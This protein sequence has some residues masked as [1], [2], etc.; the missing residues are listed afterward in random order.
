MTLKIHPPTGRPRQFNETLALDQALEL[1][2]AQ[3]YRG[4]TLRDLESQVGVTQ[5]SLYNAFGSKQQLLDSALDRYES[6]VGDELLQPLEESSEG[7]AAI[8]SFL[9]ALGAWIRAGDRRGCLIVNLMAEDGGGTDGITKRTRAY[10]RRVRT[11]LSNSLERA[12]GRKETNGEDTQARADLLLTFVLGLNVAARG[13]ASEAE[14][15]RMLDG[16]LGVVRGWA[17]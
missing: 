4:T 7:L 12:V 6:R 9:V 17:H 11:A 8:E 10:R 14:V 16:A 3:G 15:S 1:F 5:S 13:G 2:W